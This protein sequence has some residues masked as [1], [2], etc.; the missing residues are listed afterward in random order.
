MNRKGDVKPSQPSHKFVIADDD[1]VEALIG[2][3]QASTGSRGQ[4]DSDKLRRALRAATQE[5]EGA[6]DKERK[7]FFHG[8]LTG[9]AVAMK[10]G[11][12]STKA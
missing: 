11:A 2:K 12:S 4:V 7:A 3:L 10:V 5:Y 8:M 1:A 6:G 9:Y